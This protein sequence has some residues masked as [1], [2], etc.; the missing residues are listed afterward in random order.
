MTEAMTMNSGSSIE[1][2]WR[3]SQQLNGAISREAPKNPVL[4][5]QIEEILA[6]GSV[7]DH[8]SLHECGTE[9]GFESGSRD[10]LPAMK[11]RSRAGGIFLPTFRTHRRPCNGS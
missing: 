9:P 3:S 2:E 11:T 6:G 4:A 10:D 8:P 1:P 5:L 7:T